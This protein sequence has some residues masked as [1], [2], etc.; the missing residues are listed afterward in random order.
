MFWLKKNTL[1]YDRWV[2]PFNIQPLAV[3]IVL[4]IL[5]CANATSENERE[6]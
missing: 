6:Y 2:P 5:Y 1:L 3:A 4:V